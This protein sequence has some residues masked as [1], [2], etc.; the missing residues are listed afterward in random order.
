MKLTESGAI[1]LCCYF[2]NYP[3]HDELDHWFVMSKWD[4][5]ETIQ[6][7]KERTKDKWDVIYNYRIVDHLNRFKTIFFEQNN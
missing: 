7:D 4:A 6:T 2:G 3:K 5:Y 1:Q